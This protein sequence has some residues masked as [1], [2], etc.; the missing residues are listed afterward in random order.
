MNI[1]DSTD[2]TLIKELLQH[3]SLPVADISASSGIDFFSA[4]E[5]SQLI[6]VIGLETPPAG[7]TANKH[8]GMRSA[9]LR[10]LAVAPEFARQKVG[11][12]LLSHLEEVASQRHITHLYLL[13]ETAQQWFAGRGY[14]VMERDRTP[15]EL[16]NCAEFT[17][18]CPASAVLMFKQIGS[19]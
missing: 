12:S 15:D 3:Y 2:I 4:Y 6:G 16:K 17:S 8:N 14:R 18:L 11:Q 9:L 13:T 10:S 7:N 19:G 5:R 1:T